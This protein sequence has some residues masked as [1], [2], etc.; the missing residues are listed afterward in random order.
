MSE[1]RNPIYY[2]RL[3]DSIGLPS[4]ERRSLKDVVRIIN[5]L[6]ADFIM[7]GVYRHRPRPNTCEQLPRDERERCKQTGASYRL[8]REAVDFVKRRTKA[9]V[10]GGSNFQ[11]FWAENLAMEGEYHSWLGRD[12][13][14][15]L[16][17]DPREH[18]IPI[19][20]ERLHRLFARRLG[21]EVKDPKKE[22]DFYIPDPTKEEVQEIYRNILNAQLD[23]HIDAFH[24]DMIFIPVTVLLRL[25]VSVDHRGLKEIYHGCLDLIDWTKRRVRWYIQWGFH[26][27]EQQFKLF[28]K[29]SAPSIDVAMT[30]I[31]VEEI[32]RRRIDRERWREVREIIRRIYGDVEHFARID[33]GFGTTPLYVFAEELSPSEQRRFL[34]EADEVL[35]KMGILLILPVHGGN[36]CDQRQ[37]RQGKC[38]RRAY[39]KYNW[40]DSLA[41]EFNTFD[42]IKAIARGR[43]CRRV[44]RT[45]YIWERVRV[46][47]RVC[48]TVTRTVERVEW[49]WR[50]KRIGR[51]SYV[52]RRVPV[53]VRRPV[54][55]R[56]C[57][58]VYVPV[59][60]RRRRTVCRTICK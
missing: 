8:M 55:V 46:P 21:L 10:G 59:W 2:R 18:G 24:W 29:L 25:G 41:P 37:I 33:Y 23:C 48:R 27:L 28:S 9:K 12:E 4:P 35:R 3:N 5:D 34:I 57:R 26:K 44:C 32:R 36:P 19:S 50:C 38:P 42:A 54:R 13:T 15:E 49:R 7:H 16:A 17:L 53:R 43:V 11:Y 22:L 51:Y 56:V 39:G 60:R 58:T 47:R 14:W 40:Y 20:K 1:F 52:C 31:S 30:T 6:H 45:V